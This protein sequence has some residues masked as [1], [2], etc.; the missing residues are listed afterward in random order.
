MTYRA[1][2]S[3]PG[4]FLEEI[5]EQGLDAVPELIRTLLNTASGGSPCFHSS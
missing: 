3:I 1:E 2:Y 5:V 4:D